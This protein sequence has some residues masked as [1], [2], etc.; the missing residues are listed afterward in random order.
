MIGLISINYK[1]SPIE[2]REKFYFKDKITYLIVDHEPSG[3]QTINSDDDE[4]TLS[5]K[6]ILNAAK[7]E[8]YQRQMA[9][10]FLKNIDLDDWI[11]INDIDEIPNLKNINFKEIKEKFNNLKKYEFEFKNI[12]FVPRNLVNLDHTLF[13]YNKKGANLLD[14]PL[15]SLTKYSALSSVKMNYKI[16]ISVHVLFNTR[17]WLLIICK[18]FLAVLFKH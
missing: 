5:E 1:T 2:V 17:I 16:F 15:H 13:S 7:R 18:S 4:N 6:Y 14:L 3:L 11:I 9:W 8:N 12:K 10:N